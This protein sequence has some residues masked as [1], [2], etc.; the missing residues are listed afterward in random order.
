MIDALLGLITSNASQEDETADDVPEEPQHRRRDEPMIS[1]AIRGQATLM[2][3][4]EDPHYFTGA[5]PT[6][7][8]TG[9]G[10]HKEQRPLAVSLEAFAKWTLSHHSRRYFVSVKYYKL[11]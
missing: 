5:F 4:W 9:L 2:S 6:L 7:F 1:Y 10:G 3:S 8:P 11:Y